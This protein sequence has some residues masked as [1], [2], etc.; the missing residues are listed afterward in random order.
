MKPIF[1]LIPGFRSSSVWFEY[2]YDPK[3][4]KIIH[5][6]FVDKLKKMGHV[7]SV[8]FPWFNIDYYYKNPNKKEAAMWANY[9]KNLQHIC[10][11]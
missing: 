9:Y 1:L 4:K 7:Y 5:V 3:T 8:T 2:E 11:N 10:Y 6:D